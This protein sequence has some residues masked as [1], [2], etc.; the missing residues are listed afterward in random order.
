MDNSQDSHELDL[1]LP[2]SVTRPLW[3]S[4]LS[5]L[6]DRLF[7]EKLP[8]LQLTSRPMN[9][10]MLI[11]DAVSL[12]WFKTVFTNLGNVINP[13]N[14]PPLELE[15]QPVDVGELVS[16]QMGHM[17]WTSLLR[18]LA[19]RVA[20]ER[21]PPLQLTSAP[22]DADL[23]SGT[24]QLARWSSLITLPK[25]P[26]AERKF[27]ATAPARPSAPRMASPPPLAGFAG[28]SSAQLDVP[29]HAH[30]GKLQTA[31]SRSRL[32]EALLITLAG[33]EALYLLGTIFGLV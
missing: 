22:V 21:L 13:E 15:S 29:A 31:L 25:V 3:R 23:K 24:M 16:D 10:G 19:D 27:F 2:Q 5:N 14:L 30:P 18:N 33:L 12:P 32:R 9:T 7:P 28:M 8:P 20:P 26:L 11:G 17:W 6:H 4:L 1:L